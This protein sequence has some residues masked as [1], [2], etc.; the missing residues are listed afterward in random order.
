MGSKVFA[1]FNFFHLDFVLR[2][3]N[4]DH[5]PFRSKDQRI[6][7]NHEGRLPGSSAEM[8]RRVSAREELRVLVRDVHFR[9][10]GS[11][12]WINGS[13]GADHLSGER[14]FRELIKLQIRTV[15]N[16][17]LIGHAFRDGEENAKRFD[18]R[19]GEKCAS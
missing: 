16:G 14:S 13:R 1:D 5:G 17:Y 7:R 4:S 15:T 2:S 3:D 19:Y 10:Q 12:N 8:D 9:Q 11:R 6:C 18:L